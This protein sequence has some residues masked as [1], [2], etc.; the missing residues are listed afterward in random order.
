MSKIYRIRD[1]EDGSVYPMTLPMILKEL[2]RDR[3]E[4]WTNYDE[5]DWR[6]GLAEFTTYEVVENEHT[7]YDELWEFLHKCDFQWEC[8]ADDENIIDEVRIRAVRIV[9]EVEDG[10]EHE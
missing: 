10:G 3:S 4:E 8:V 7:E 6:E 9:F 1:V 2:N 5:T